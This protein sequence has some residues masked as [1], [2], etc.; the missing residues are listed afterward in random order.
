MEH[1]VRGSRPQTLLSGTC[2]RDAQLEIVI[3]S[4]SYMEH[5]CS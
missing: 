1:A 4:E 3:V 5:D 2:L